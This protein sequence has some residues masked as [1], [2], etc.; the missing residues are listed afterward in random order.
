MNDNLDPA[1]YE[2]WYHSRRGAWIG[3]IELALMLELMQPSDGATLL[4]VGSGT[5]YFSR[6]FAATGLR[7][8]GIEPNVAMLHYARD[9]QGPVAYLKGTAARL[10][11]ADASIDYVTAVTSLCF[12]DN[13]ARALS[14]MWRVAKRG[15]LLGLLNKTSLLYRRKHGNSGYRG[16]RWDRIDDVYGW[17]EGLSPAP[18]RITGGSCV[19]FPDGSIGGR[20]MERF[21]PTQLPWGGF[22]AIYL[23]KPVTIVLTNRTTI[24][25]LMS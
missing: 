21:L 13:P 3:N 4:D 16:A 5:G 22:L 1:A 8:I 18:A 24:T 10:P 12:I 14:A 7:V 11:F 25:S 17:A 19:F 2:A 9:R 6:R 20:F 23:Q 15:V